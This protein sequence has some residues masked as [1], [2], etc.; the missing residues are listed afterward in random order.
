LILFYVQGGGLGHLSRT[1]KLIQKLNLKDDDVLIITPSKFTHHF[2]QYR[3]VN[4]LWH[5]SS[6]NWSK[7]I[8]TTL[9]KYKVKLCYI[10]TF[11]LGIKGELINVFKQVKYVHYIYVARILKWEKYLKD[12]SVFSPFIYSETLVLEKL[13]KSHFN[14][15]LE[16]SVN[17]KEINLPIAKSENPIQLLDKPYAI[18]VHSGGKK[19]L[20]HLCDFAEK[21]CELKMQIF[22]FT[23]IDLTYTNARFTF[24]KGTFPVSAYFKPASK[25]FTAGGFNLIQELKLY[26]KKHIA[27][28]MDRLYDD[29][30]FR[31]Q[32]EKKTF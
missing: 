7:I 23:Q 14:W 17:V 4:L 3:F 6:Q 22:V 1:H 20:K 30:G 29:Q 2:S 25:I 19:D 9:L 15:I 27:L 28:A 16:H 31:I 24:Q 32:Q 18:V 26:S 13:Y 11:P 12:I 10:D 21:V 5:D 8:T